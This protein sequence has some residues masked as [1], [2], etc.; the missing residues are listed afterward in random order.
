MF[1]PHPGPQGLSFPLCLPK[2]F[3]CPLRPSSSTSSRKPSLTC[4]VQNYN[5]EPY[6]ATEH[7]KC[8]RSLRN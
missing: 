4:T 3:A 6:V 8:V 1:A 2:S 7:L 5:H